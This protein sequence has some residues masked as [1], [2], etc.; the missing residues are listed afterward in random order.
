MYIEEILQAKSRKLTVKALNAIKH[1]VVE[2]NVGTVFVGRK[3]ECDTYC[4]QNSGLRA[5]GNWEVTV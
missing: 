3:S 4:K 2:E 1:H 5:K